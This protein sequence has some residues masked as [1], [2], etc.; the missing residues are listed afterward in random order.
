ME[1]ECLSHTSVIFSVCTTPNILH[2]V[3]ALCLITADHYCCAHPGPV[4][5]AGDTLRSLAESH[6]HPEVIKYLDN[7]SADSAGE[8]VAVSVWDCLAC[9]YVSHI[10]RNSRVWCLLCAV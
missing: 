8:V 4:N 1:V 2:A 7:H 5:G 9:G 10:G 3:S 6:G